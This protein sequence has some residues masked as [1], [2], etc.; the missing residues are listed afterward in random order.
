MGWCLREK[1]EEIMQLG[2][3]GLVDE[4]DKLNKIELD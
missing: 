2:M 1:L 4:I 3:F